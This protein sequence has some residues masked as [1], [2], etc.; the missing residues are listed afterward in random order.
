MQELFA[1]NVLGFWLFIMSECI[2]FGCFFATYVILHN[3][4]AGGPSGKELFDPTL[5]LA[6]T[7]IL[8]FSNLFIE[9]TQAAT[10]RGRAIFFFSLTLSLGIVFFTLVLGDFFHFYSL[11]ATWERSGFLSAY[12]SLVGIFLFHF[13]VGIL[14]LLILMGQIAVRGIT[15]HSMRR[16]TLLRLF[17]H[18]LNVVWLFIFAIVYLLGVI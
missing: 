14:W 6:E 18:F 5:V 3:N 15:P 13:S 17:W 2:L 1:R 7:I 10:G 8:L 11:G 16:T 4:T 9:P 12:F